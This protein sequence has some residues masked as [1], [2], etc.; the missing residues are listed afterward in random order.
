MLWSVFTHASARLCV[1]VRACMYVTKCWGSYP[2]PFFHK[3]HMQVSAK[4]IE[5]ITKNFGLRCGAP[6]WQSDCFTGNPTVIF[7]AKATSSFRGKSKWYFTV[8]ATGVIRWQGNRPI[9]QWKRQVL[10]SNWMQLKVRKV[11]HLNVNTL[12]RWGTRGEASCLRTYKV[13]SSLRVHY[14]FLHL[15]TTW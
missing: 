1:H 5:A 15:C 11:F 3:Q 8:K 6:T 7:R 13:V 2:F 10:F 14:L 4:S 12:G 9:P